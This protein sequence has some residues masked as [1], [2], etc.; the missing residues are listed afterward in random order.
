M[1][2]PIVV[3]Y[4]RHDNGKRSVASVFE[5]A[6]PETTKEFVEWLWEQGLLDPNDEFETKTKDVP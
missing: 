2:Y 5:A 6:K 3:T 4:I 1:M